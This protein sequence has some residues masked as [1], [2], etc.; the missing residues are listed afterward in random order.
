M[1]AMATS[2]IYRVADPIG[3]RETGGR[4]AARPIPLMPIE[5]TDSMMVLSVVLAEQA[6]ERFETAQLPRQFIRRLA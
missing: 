6:S 1:E 4:V 3:I 2:R 5:N